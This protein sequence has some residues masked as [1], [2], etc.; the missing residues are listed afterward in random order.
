VLYCG[1]CPT[2]D[3]GGILGLPVNLVIDREGRIA[4][5]HDGMTDLP[6][7]EKEVQALLLAPA[8]P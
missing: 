7:L 4:A 8:K 1:C 3:Y 5:R 6:G 2:E